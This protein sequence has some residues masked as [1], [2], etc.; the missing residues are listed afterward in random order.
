VTPRSIEIERF[1]W[2]TQL[3]VSGLKVVTADPLAL[4]G[5]IR[6]WETVVF[7]PLRDNTRMDVT[8]V[9]ALGQPIRHVRWCSDMLI[10]PC[11]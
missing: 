2:S 7:L 5:S 8:V 11:Y 3:S 9:F 1:G 6:R 10:T 4:T